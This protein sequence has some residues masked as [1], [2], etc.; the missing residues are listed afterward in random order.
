MIVCGTL[1]IRFRHGEYSAEIEE[2]RPV[3]SFVT[4]VAARSKSSLFYELVG[5]NN[6]NIFAVNP[7]SGVVFV[8][9]PL[10]YERGNFYNLT[11]RASNAVSLDL[12]ITT[13]CSNS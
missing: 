12:F 3:G 13:R 2:N 1:A 9:G 6:D 5:G 7:S 8:V 10:D 11:V 4:S